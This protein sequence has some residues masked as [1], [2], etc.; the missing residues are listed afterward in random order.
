MRAKNAGQAGSAYVWPRRRRTLTRR[1]FYNEC[2]PGWL[3]ALAH[4]WGG[5][6][7]TFLLWNATSLRNWSFQLNSKTGD[8]RKLKNRRQ[9]D[10]VL[11]VPSKD[12]V[13][14]QVFL[15]HRKC[16]QNVVDKR[17]QRNVVNVSQQWVAMW[18][19]LCFLC[20]HSSCLR[21]LKPIYR[22]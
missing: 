14:F 13:T 3:C 6:F 15:Q 17:N 8:S 21:T 1:L 5:C 9:S 20:G 16:F 19:N 7:Y 12:S 2:S 11:L 4:S 22:L 10:H 18:H